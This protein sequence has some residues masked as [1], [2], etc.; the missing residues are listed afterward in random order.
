ML[1]SGIDSNW[2]GI[3]TINGLY[4]ENIAYCDGSCLGNGQKDAIAGI[5]VYWSPD[6]TYN[7]SEPLKVTTTPTNNMA[8]LMAVI[9][10]IQSGLERN[11]TNVTICTDSQYVLL[12]ANVDLTRRKDIANQ[13]L[14]VELQKMCKHKDIKVTLMLVKAHSDCVG[15]KMADKLAKNGAKSLL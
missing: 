11:F 8:E 14:I 4:K 12:S 2:R 15:N 1:I 3:H 5:G 9:R 13:E 10:G 7:I 6:S